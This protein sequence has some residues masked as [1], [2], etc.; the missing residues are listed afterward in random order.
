MAGDVLGLFGTGLLY[1][2]SWVESSHT[3]I[4]SKLTPLFLQREKWKKQAETLR[5]QKEKLES[6]CRSLQME[7]KNAL[8]SSNSKPQT[9][10][11][12][13]AGKAAASAGER[14]S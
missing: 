14:T 4:T 7:R 5:A 6:L 10:A 8:A 2:S 1:R 11:P 13:P 9:A 3:L 12:A